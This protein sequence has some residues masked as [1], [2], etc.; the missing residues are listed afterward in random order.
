MHAHP[1]H[2]NE[3]S[4]TVWLGDFNRHHP[5][6]DD[7]SNTHLFTTTN[8]DTASPLVDLLGTFGMEM[9]LPA[10]IPTIETFRTGSLSRPDN[11]FC[12]TSL[13][14]AFIECNTKP[15]LCPACTDHFPITGTIDLSPDRNAP[16]PRHNWKCVE[17]DDFR[18]ALHE[19]LQVMGLVCPIQD[20][21]DFLVVFNLLTAAIQSATD[22]HD[23]ETKPSPYAKW[24]WSSKPAQLRRHKCCLKSKSYRLC[25]Q[26][27]HLVHK[28]A[29]KAVNEYAMKIEK[30]KK[31]T[32]GRLAGGCQ[33]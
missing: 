16:T 20:K 22:Q 5:L 25:A 33:H 8:L 28:E 7:P 12:S 9:P 32:L 10:G 19:N 27:F 21:E 15:K 31:K 14:E 1:L 6:W 3:T 30:V 24:W 26:R 17:W 23:P 2:Q 11:V 13:L 29:K 4:K 18:T